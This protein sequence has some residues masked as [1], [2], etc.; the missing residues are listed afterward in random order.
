MTRHLL[1]L[2]CF[3]LI[4]PGCTPEQSWFV[5]ALPEGPLV[6]S[7]RGGA[8]VAPENTLVAFERSAAADIQAEVM[9][10]DVHTSA[11]GE[12]VVIHDHTI[13]RVTGEG[14]GCDFEQD[15]ETETYGV[16]HVNDLTLAELQSYNAGYC[17]EDPDAAEDAEEDERFPYRENGVA[18]GAYVPALRTVLQAYPTQRFIVEVKQNDPSL[19][20]PLMELIDEEG[21]IQR[22][23]FSNFDPDGTA[24]L[25]EAMPDGACLALSS[26][27]IR[28]WAS[29][30]IMPFGGG[31]CEAYDLGSV[32]HENGGFDMKSERFVGNIQAT[33]APVFMWTIN[34]QQLMKQVL[35]LG[36]DGVITDRPDL[37]REMVGLVE[38]T[39]GD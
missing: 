23:C 31:S 18:Y 3:A 20:E 8:Q 24:E 36:V 10:L 19:V 12:L 22:V 9:E 17:W 7:H 15:T 14:N 39:S 33:G 32:P 5:K 1:V 25:A 29:E 28:C 27:G 4:A 11:D 16:I 34:D 38:S 13:D 30:S 2:I 35:D 26:E 21:A 37:L 6:V